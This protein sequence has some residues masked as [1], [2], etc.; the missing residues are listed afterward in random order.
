MEYFS[1][2]GDALAKLKW[3]TPGSTTKG[4]YLKEKEIASKSDYV[5]V[6]LG[7]NTRIEN[8]G[9]DKKDLNLPKDQEDF[10]R[11]LNKAN[12]RTIVVLEAG[13]WQPVGN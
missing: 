3:K 1:S 13:S 9:R 12:P 11:E 6:V 5:I 7:L 4:M 10:I 8:E 2:N